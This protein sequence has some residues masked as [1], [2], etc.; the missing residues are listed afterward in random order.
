M[1]DGSGM[2][3]LVFSAC[4]LPDRG[5][6]DYDYVMNNLFWYLLG[7]LDSM[8]TDEYIIVYLHGATKQSCM[9]SYRWL[10][11]CYK[12]GVVV[13]LSQLGSI[14]EISEEWLAKLK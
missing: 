10:G 7:T 8:V 3:I 2:P 13:E 1:D 5:R 14:C 12:V 9:P 4:H 6:L 11:R